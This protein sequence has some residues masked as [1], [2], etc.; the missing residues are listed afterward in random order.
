MEAIGKVLCGYQ[1]FD[2]EPVYETV[3]EIEI[4]VRKKPFTAKLYY[5]KGLSKYID[6]KG[7]EHISDIT[8]FYDCGPDGVSSTFTRV[9]EVMP[10]KEECEAG[11]Q[12]IREIVTQC[13]VRQG[14]W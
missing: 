2:M 1:C 13:M 5:R 14:I 9:P 11:R 10:T 12:R 7:N 3:E 4:T 8:T 6:P